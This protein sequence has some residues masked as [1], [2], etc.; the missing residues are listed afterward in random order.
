MTAATND[1]TLAGRLAAYDQWKRGR[2]GHAAGCAPAALAAAPLGRFCVVDCRE[3]RGG[4][5]GVHDMSRY[6]LVA[7]EPLSSG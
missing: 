5:T 6:L 7:R 4:S 3:Q 1:Q 2:V